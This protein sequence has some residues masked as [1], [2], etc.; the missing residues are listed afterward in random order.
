MA[1]TSTR[2]ELLTWLFGTTAAGALAGCRRTTEPSFGGEFHEGAFAAAHRIRDGQLPPDADAEPVEVPVLVLGGGIAGLSAAWRL[3]RSGFDRF[4]V[5]DLES[6]PG[7][8]ARGDRS[9]VTSYPWGAHYL[10]AP[11]KTNAPLVELCDDLGFVAGYDDAGH[12]QYPE[13]LLVADPEERVYFE[14]AWH[15]G[16]LPMHAA[17]TADREQLERFEAK[18]AAFVDHRTDGRRAFTLPVDEGV[19][20]EDLDAMTFAAWLDREG[21]DAPFVRHLADYACRDDYGTVPETTSAWYGL[22]YFAARTKQGGGDS[23][24]FLSWSNGNARIADGIVARIGQSRFR[25][26][27]V[28]ASVAPEG[29]GRRVR[30]RTWDL[31]LR[32]S[33]TW[34]AEQVIFALPSF[35][36]RYLIQG[37]EVPAYHPSYA[38][39]LVAN[40]HLTRRPWSPG[41]ETAWDNTIFDSRSLGYVVATH[42]DGASRGP[43][44]WTHY[45]P[46]LGD[47]KTA[48]R[49][50]LEMSWSEATDAVVR[51]LARTHEDF[52]KSV[53]RIDV[54]R[55]G[56]GMVRPTPGTR[57]DSARRAA[58]R[59]V[60][61]VHFAHTDLSGV[62]LFEEAFAHG[63]RAAREVLAALRGAR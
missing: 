24:P 36:R 27:T 2:R 20:F 58:A 9:N 53:E 40:V 4:F 14:G 10:P 29:D 33:T 18:V 3:H 19:G 23:A 59:P 42:Q 52:E 35:L 61:P 8:T 22:H 13:H 17:T 12:P 41:F 5:L 28:I 55:W 39:W 43:T 48:R 7:G 49:S 25:P 34:I 26:F 63:D 21:F 51:E 38:P 46:L 54:R 31:A 30:V 16:H 6:A 50:L 11:P 60:G 57:T 45:T 15:R 62:A 44:V 56:H 32:R 1:L 37:Y 47:P